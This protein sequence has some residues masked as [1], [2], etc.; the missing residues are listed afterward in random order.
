MH[1]ALLIKKDTS[2]LN[3]QPYAKGASFLLQVF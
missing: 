2:K 1:E 3:R